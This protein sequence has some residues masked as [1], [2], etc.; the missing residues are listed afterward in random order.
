[1]KYIKLT[2]GVS[3][4]VDDDVFDWA[5]LIK[6][7]AHRTGHTYYAFCQRQNR[8]IYLHRLILRARK[9]QEVDHID[10][11]GLNNR[12]TNLR[13]T[14]HAGNARSFQ[15]PREGKT[16][17]YRGVRFHSRDGRWTAQIKTMGRNLFLGYHDSERAAARAY[18]KKAKGLWGKVACL[19][20]PE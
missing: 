3:T 19:N 4:V 8:S 1:M 7:T 2:Q 6:W 16:S 14:T 18:D 13:L 9:G 20:F 5:S 11:D 10:G 12:L 17:R 15:T